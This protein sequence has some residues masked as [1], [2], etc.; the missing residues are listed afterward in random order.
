VS[1]SKFDVD[2]PPVTP[3]RCKEQEASK[4]QRRLC[5]ICFSEFKFFL[6]RFFTCRM[7]KREVCSDC[8]QM[9]MKVRFMKTERICISC[10]GNGGRLEEENI[11]RAASEFSLPHELSQG[12][13]PY[14]MMNQIPERQGPVIRNVELSQGNEPLPFGRFGTA[15]SNH[16]PEEEKGTCRTEEKEIV[17]RFGL[18]PVEGFIEHDGPPVVQKQESN[19]TRKS[20]RPVIPLL[21]LDAVGSITK[22]GG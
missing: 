19:D 5:R 9:R 14:N 22:S 11:G 18:E 7:C 13:L 20:P 21:K 4:T 16:D 1:S 12:S 10:F 15:T 2:T 3:R 17:P 8:A 6:N